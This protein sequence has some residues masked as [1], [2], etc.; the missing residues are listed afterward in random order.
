[1]TSGGLLVAS[2]ALAGL[3]GPAFASPTLGDGPA[4]AAPAPAAPAPAT[5]TLGGNQLAAPGL[6]VDTSAGVPALPTITATSFVVVDAD[7]GNVLAAHNAHEKLAP[8]STLK[9]LTA[10]TLLPKL[11]PATTIVGT[12]DAPAVDGTKAGIVTGT[13]YTVGNLF[14]AMLMMSANDAAVELADVNGGLAPTL[15]QMNAEAAHLQADDTVALTPDGLDAAGQSSSAYDLALIFRAGMKL[16]SFQHYL[17]L[18]SA[19]FPAPNHGS[20]QIQTHDELLNDYPGMIGGKNG[21]TIAADASYVG[22]ASR[23]GKTIIVALMR[24][25]PNFWPEA[26]A[27]LNWGFAADPVATPVGTLISPLVPKPPVTA[28]SAAARQQHVKVTAA[29]SVHHGGSGIVDV[30]GWTAAILVALLSAVAALRIRSLNRRHRR[31][32]DNYLATLSRL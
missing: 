21:Y 22:A 10:L 12:S 5:D 27:L 19:A 23:G 9:T 32:H 24:D 17:S 3:A 30:L 8:A 15:A 4:P 2:F 14:T 29:R 31:R 16:P 13:T 7:T 1:M 20:F 18:H 28:A 6:V 25:Q 11:Q 26:K